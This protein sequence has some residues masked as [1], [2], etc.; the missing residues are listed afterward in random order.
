[1][2]AAEWAML[3]SARCA[4]TEKVAVSDTAR[5][6][7]PEGKRLTVDGRMITQP[8]LTKDRPHLVQL[9]DGAT[10]SVESV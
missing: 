9:I 7:I 3:A 1:M 5:L 2:L 8:A 10:N 6:N 4:K